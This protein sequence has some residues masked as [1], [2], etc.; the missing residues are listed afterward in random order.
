[1]NEHRKKEKN[2][3][4]TS[5]IQQTKKNMKSDHAIEH[6][7]LI[8]KKTMS[9]QSQVSSKVTTQALNSYCFGLSGTKNQ[10]GSIIP[11]TFP[12]HS[13]TFSKTSAKRF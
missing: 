12:G 7:N 3:L 13:F 4:K 11:K 8:T 10:S 5:S 2:Y 1:M 9:E 6:S